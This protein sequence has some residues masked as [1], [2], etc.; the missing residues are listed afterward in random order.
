MKND[1]ENSVFTI[2]NNNEIH[3]KI[4]KSTYGEPEEEETD[5]GLINNSNSKAILIGS[6]IIILLVGLLPLKTGDVE[7]IPFYYFGFIFFIAGFFIGTSIP[8]FGII[9]LFSHGMTG[10]G[11]MT[12][13]T[14]L[15]IINNPYMTDNPKNIYIYL[16]VI[17]VLFAVAVIKTII[18]SLNKLKN[19]SFSYKKTNKKNQA[20][21]ILLFT[22]GIV[23]V[24]V[25]PFIVDKLLNI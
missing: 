2:I 11:L 16:G 20:I 18:D 10:L 17:C 12:V 15:N 22:V 13:P 14:L 25:L 7:S 3:D 1:D 24:E 4:Y 21:I 23:L 19:I 6:I 5:W 9:F 8:G